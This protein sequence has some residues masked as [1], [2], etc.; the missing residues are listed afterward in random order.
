M[1]EPLDLEVALAGLARE[2]DW[3]ATP[4]LNAAVRR[5]IAARPRWYASRWALAAIAV[6]V[7]L[8]TLVA[9]TP[10]RTAIADWVN[11][12]TSIKRTTSVPTP[13]SLPPGP[14]GRRLGLGNQTSLAAARAGVT[15]QVLLPTGLGAPDEV[16][17][18]N[19][20]DGPS[21][22]EVTLVYGQR[23][24]I[25]ESGQT[26]V[27]VLVTEAR[28]RVNEN[29]FGK[30]V[31]P[32]T[33]IEPITVEGHQGWWISGQPH[34]FF[35]DDGTGNP[36]METLRLATNTLLIDEGGTI[37][38]IEGDLTRQQALDLAASLS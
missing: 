1:P 18:Q 38:R 24:G 19:P 17:L 11:L 27:S 28:G 5:R 14:L 8:A 2:L 30:T 4:N 35:F 16:Y 12:H 22:G 13:S 34:V 36:R 20:P 23:L 25:P 3:P 9:Y 10:T 26:G 7:T 32:D 31:G 29:F 33:T 15:W 37:V 21:D 6:I